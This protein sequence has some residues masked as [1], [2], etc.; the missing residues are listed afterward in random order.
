MVSLKSLNML[1]IHSRVKKGATLY[2]AILFLHQKDKAQQESGDK[3]S[4]VCE[5]VDTREETDGEINA[6]YDD[7]LEELRASTPVARPIGDKFRGRCPQEAEEGT[8]CT[9]GDGVVVEQGRE[10][11]AAK[12]RNEVE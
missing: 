12:A 1:W 11:T 5:I 10:K 6:C 4:N 8:R 7:E 3:A 2:V 9:D